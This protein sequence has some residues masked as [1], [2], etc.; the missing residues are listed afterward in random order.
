MTSG[1][2]VG[3][4]ILGT[5]VVADSIAR[6]LAG[7][8][9]RVVV[10]AS[11]RAERAAGF[12]RRHGARA[13]GYEDAAAAADVRAVYVAT[14]P[15]EH[16]RQ[17]LHALAAGKAVLIEKPF[18][19]DAAAAARIAEAAR[20]AG[21]FCMEAMWTRFQPLI[22][23]IRA[24]VA[25][26]EIG[27][28]RQFHGAFCI[29]DVPDPAA[30]L[31]DPARGGGA[32]M[33]RGIYPLSLARHLLG[34]VEDLQAMARIGAT[35]VDEDCALT[36]RHASGALSVLRASLSSNGPNGMV[37]QGTRGTIRVAAPIYRPPA[38][39]LFATTPRT[40]GTGGGTGGGA[41]GAAGGDAGG[42][43]A[44]GLRGNP[45]VH[46]LWQ[47]VGPALRGLRPGGRRLAAPY[48]GTGYGHQLQ[49]V[50]AA[51]AAGETESPLMPL[52]ESV[53][54]MGLVDAARDRWGAR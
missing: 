43:G 50:M 14:P 6:A 13:A 53:E 21:S 18:A 15:S 54:I 40:G 32:L 31:F 16:E 28:V 34:P 44:G 3:W 2:P 8:G 48:A 42:G 10:V 7:Q 9:G 11:R 27:E 29:A 25:A 12:A 20:R 37:I 35:G 17:A 22:A 38:A 33:H 49:A 45:R 26:G 52:A 4:A 24:R 1:G 46:A 47:R 51:L 5:G 41:G 39:R 36:L 19:T 30:S 23:A